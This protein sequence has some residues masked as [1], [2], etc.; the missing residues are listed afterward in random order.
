MSAGLRRIAA[1]PRRLAAG[2]VCALATVASAA[3][4]PGAN[5]P[6]VAYRQRLGAVLPLDAPFVDA[7]GGAVRL[8]DYF[9]GDAAHPAVPVLVVLGYYRCRN[10]CETEMEGV[11]Q[12]LAASGLARRDYRV[13]AVS[14]DPDETPADAAARRRLDLQ[15][16]DFS[17]THSTDRAAEQP[18]TLDALVG[19]AASIE[20]LTT[21]AGF[22]FARD[23][24]P[25]AASG[26]EVDQPTTFAHAAGFLVATP[27]G[28]ISQYFLGVRHDPVALRRAVDEAAGDAI[29]RAVDSLFLLCA[30]LDP[31]LGRFTADVML[32]L[33]LLGLGLALLLGTWIWRYRRSPTSDPRT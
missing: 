31:T 19:P 25:A 15:V 23:K 29:G 1:G 4:Y 32:G 17:V 9:R 30:H 18:P 12:A 3:I 8:G 6:P 7:S 11:L 33:R 20:R 28:R 26:S 5:A 10:L 13:L 2:L 24:A 16:A 22:I 14:I 21:Q 27:D